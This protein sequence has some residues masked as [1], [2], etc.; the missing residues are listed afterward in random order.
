LADVA[1]HNA[2]GDMWVVVDGDVYDLSLFAR[3]HP[4]GEGVLLPHAG[5]DA[6]DIFFELH[7]LEVLG[8]YPQLKKGRLV[9]AAGSRPAWRGGYGESNSKG[10]LVV[11]GGGGGGDKMD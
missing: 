2:P 5:K 6:T 10:A 11:V 7:K 8:R 9:S 3:F 4:G 1:R